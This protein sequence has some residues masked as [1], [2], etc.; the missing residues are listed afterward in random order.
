VIEQ[1]SQ[2]QMAQRHI[3]LYKRILEGKAGVADSGK[4]QAISG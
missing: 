3:A 4:R 2:S 1:F